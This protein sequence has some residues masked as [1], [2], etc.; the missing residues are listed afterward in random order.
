MP[1]QPVL[2]SKSFTKWGLD[3]VGVINP[4][5][6]GGHQFILMATDYCTRWTEAQACKK[7]TSEVV[8]LFLEE[9]IVTRF[10]VS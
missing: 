1:L 5:S 7:T 8:I 3:F 9:F 4:N 10:G 6:S 2:E